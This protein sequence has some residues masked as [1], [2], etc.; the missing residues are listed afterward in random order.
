MTTGTARWKNANTVLAA[1]GLIVSVVIFVVTRAYPYAPIAIGGSP[2]FYPRVLA[3]FL[4]LLSISVF[5]EG[6]IRRVRVTFPTKTNLVRLLGLIGLL[7]LTPLV[8]EWLGFRIMGIIVA[9]G[10]MLLLSDWR[11]LDARRLA[12]LVVTAIGATLALYFIFESVAR[13]P[14][15]RGRVF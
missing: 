9:L 7:A 11:N 4:A 6:W 14:L 1:L 8:F 12:V 10:T 5:V 3:V 2:G 13:V 15:P